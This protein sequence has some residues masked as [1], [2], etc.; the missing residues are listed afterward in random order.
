VDGVSDDAWIAIARAEAA[1]DPDAAGRVSIVLNLLTRQPTV[2]KFGWKAQVPT[3]HQFSGDAL[4]NEVGITNPDFPEGSC[5]NGD[6]SLLDFNPD[7]GCT[8]AARTASSRRSCGT[9]ASCF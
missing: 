5:P 7:A 9:M 1:V 3:L 2:G 6:C 4:M 8:T